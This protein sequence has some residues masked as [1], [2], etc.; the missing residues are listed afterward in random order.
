MSH[1]RSRKKLETLMRDIATYDAEESL[2]SFFDWDDLMHR[3]FV[4]FAHGGC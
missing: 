2:L 3:T 1:T 4:Y